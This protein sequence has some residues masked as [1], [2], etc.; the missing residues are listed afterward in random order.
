LESDAPKKLRMILMRVSARPYLEEMR[1]SGLIYMNPAKFFHNLENQAQGDRFEGSQWVIQPKDGGNLYLGDRKQG[2][3]VVFTPEEIVGPVS[4]YTRGHNIFCMYSVSRPTDLFPV[5]DRINEFGD[6]FILVTNTLEFVRRLCEASENAALPFQAGLV[7]YQDF[8]TYSGDTGLFVKALEYEWQ[9][10]YRFVVY[11]GKGEPL[12]LYLGN[13]EDITT[14]VLSMDKLH[15]ILDLPEA[16]A[17][18]FG[19]AW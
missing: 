19:F 13:I 16:K 11:T 3:A 12:K 8:S 5:N 9:R 10:E 6:S 4:A 18:Q 15:E 1:L 2:Q 17:R 14:P 7:K